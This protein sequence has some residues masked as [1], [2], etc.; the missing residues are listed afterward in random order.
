MD[1]N[2]ELREAKKVAADLLKEKADADA[3]WH[4]E[5]RETLRQQG[6]D[7]AAIKANTNNYSVLQSR[8]EALEIR[9]KAIEDFKIKAVAQMTGA[10]AVLAILWKLIDRIWR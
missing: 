6:L 1:H 2:E 4:Q 3:R 10:F 8:N 7:I 5:V 9:I